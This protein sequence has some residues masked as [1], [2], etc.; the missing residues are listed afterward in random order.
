MNPITPLPPFAPIAPPPAPQILSLRATDLPARLS[1]RL[2]ANEDLP[3]KL[4]HFHPYKSK[5]LFLFRSLF[6][7]LKPTHSTPKGPS[8]RPLSPHIHKGPVHSTSTK[9][10][11]SHT[12]Q[13]LSP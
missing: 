9:S 3:L 2:I 13:S 6:G 11:V 1:R 5:L 12:F 10:I 7:K 4:S 8:L